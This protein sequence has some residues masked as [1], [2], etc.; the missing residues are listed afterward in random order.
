MSRKEINFSDQNAAKQALLYAGEVCR[1]IE[2]QIFIKQ[3]KPIFSE[4]S[5]RFE[6][7]LLVNSH[8]L[9]INMYILLQNF[10]PF[11][12]SYW[13]IESKVVGVSAE[14]GGD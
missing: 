8:D 7:P 5:C 13:S 11:S 4:Q 2:A 9:G 1:L 10:E 14:C 3:A 12:C 6:G